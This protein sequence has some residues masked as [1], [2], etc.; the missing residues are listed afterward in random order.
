MLARIGEGSSRSS[1][2]T[3]S[4]TGM[5]AAKALQDQ[6]G[7]R[8]AEVVGAQADQVIGEHG[9]ILGVETVVAEVREEGVV[10]RF[11]VFAFDFEL[12]HRH[13]LGELGHL[14]QPLA[15]G[16]DRLGAAFEHERIGFGDADPFV[17]LGRRRKEALRA[18]APPAG[19]GCAGGGFPPAAHSA[20]AAVS[21]RDIAPKSNAPWCA[22]PT[23]AF[24]RSAL[25][26]SF[27][28][29]KSALRISD[30]FMISLPISARNF[31]AFCSCNPSR[32]A[33]TAGTASPGR[34]R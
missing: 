23:A 15:I 9:D 24:S 10:P 33:E 14:R 13:R 8:R 21:R 11:A 16:G 28:R 2:C 12:G 20:V 32:H 25:M 5:P 4:F 17:A 22:D 3:T 6:V 19:R 26:P 27:E 29:P 7:I 31:C 30:S 18:A 34:S 1:V